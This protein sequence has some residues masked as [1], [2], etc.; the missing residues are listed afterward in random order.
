MRGDL[1]PPYQSTSSSHTNRL[2]KVSKHMDDSA[3]QVDVG[4]IMPLVVM[5]VAVAMGAVVVAVI[6][7]MVMSANTMVVVA[8]KYEQV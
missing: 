7:V 6:M 1:L 4:V 5:A 8:T 2:H 3:P